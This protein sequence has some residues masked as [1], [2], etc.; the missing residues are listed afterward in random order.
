MKRNMAF[1]NCLQQYTTHLSPI[2]NLFLN[3][4]N[5]FILGINGS[6]I[7][8]IVGFSKIPFYKI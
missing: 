1:N 3:F 4:T 5:R 6:T 8:N 2:S 7:N